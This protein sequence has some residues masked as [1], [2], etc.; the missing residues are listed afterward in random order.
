MSKSTITQIRV[1]NNK[2]YGR[3]LNGK[4]VA[5]QETTKEN[6]QTLKSENRNAKRLVNRGG[7]IYY[8]ILEVTD[9]KDITQI[10]DEEGGV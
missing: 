1:L 8:E 9:F 2:I 6:Y 10:P 5:L 7:Y 4:I 3:D